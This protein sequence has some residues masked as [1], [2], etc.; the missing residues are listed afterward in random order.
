L[1]GWNIFF[2]EVVEMKR[3]ALLL[4]GVLVIGIPLFAGGQSGT[5]AASAGGLTTL[6]VWGVNQEYVSGS[7]SVT[8][9]DWY[10]G[11]VPSKIWDAFVGEMAKRG[12]KLELD[13]VALD[14]VGTVFQTM[15]ASGQFDN[16]DLV[17]AQ[18]LSNQQFNNLVSQKRIYSISQAI[19]QYSDGTAR[20]FFA[21]GIGKTLSKFYAVDDGNFYWVPAF[22]MMYYKDQPSGNPTM[23]M[24]R[25][26]WLDKL[27]LNIPTTTDELYNAL[28]AFRDRDVNGNGIKDEVAEVSIEGFQNGIAQL[29]GLAADQLSPY[30]GYVNGNALSPWY[31]PNIQ[32]YFRFMNRLYTAGLLRTGGEPTDS[33]NNKIGYGYRWIMGTGEADIRVPSGEKGAYWAPFLFSAV[34]GIKG[35]LWS[36]GNLSVGNHGAIVVPSASKNIEKVTRVFDYLVSDDFFTLMEAGIEGYTYNL[37]TDGYPV[38]FKSNDQVG[39]DGL[40]NVALWYGIFPWM[41]KREQFLTLTDVVDVGKTLGYPNGFTQKFDFMDQIE[42]GK[43]FNLMGYESGTLAL[44]TAQEAARLAEL[45]PDLATYSSELSSAL[46]MGEKSLSNWSTYMADLKRLGLDEVLAICQARLDRVK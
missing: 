7:T 14:Q 34:P 29:Y 31:Q 4:I 1:T 42:E 40:I 35:T 15:L 26:D 22:Y 2:V 13:L 25:K 20:N 30:F 10:D 38:R 16:Y 27:G 41:Q 36:T 23:G 5:S 6:K 46:I 12:I 17:S 11:K 39:V 19:N 18:G 44:P 24:I 28:F 21:N 32:D 9:Q 43:T 37:N 3:I 45:L 33:I 8:M